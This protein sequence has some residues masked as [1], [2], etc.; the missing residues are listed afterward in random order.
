[1]V[2]TNTLINVSFFFNMM[3]FLKLL[4]IS[5]KRYFS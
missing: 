3:P 2:K 4:K 5:T 1:M